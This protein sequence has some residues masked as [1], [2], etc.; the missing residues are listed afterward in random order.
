[1]ASAIQVSSFVNQIAPN[2]KIE[3]QKNG[4]KVC[5]PII[6][7]ACIE[8]AF[9]TSSLAY[10][11][12]NYFGLKAGSSWKGKSVNLKTKEEY[13]VG[14]LTTIR[15]NFRVYD[16][17][18]DGV[19]GYFEFISTPRYSNLKM[20]ETPQQYLEFIK[21]DGYA[22]SSTYVQT[23]M[24]CINKYNLTQF[25]FDAPQG[26][27]YTLTATIMKKG[28]KGE[29]VKWLQYTLNHDFGYDLVCDGDFGQKTEKAVKEVQ[30]K[31]FVDGIVGKLTL[32][33]LQ[34]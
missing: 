23:V 31:F 7:Q 3:A 12:F 14:T 18:L 5:S 29:S 8:S 15:D 28:S 17:M 24:N 20:A 26:N 1:M 9:G 19:K 11:Y 2:I 22:T 33:K 27:P 34:K 25:D 16:N 30:M 32:E 10:K 13:T 6:G 21:Q 4:Y